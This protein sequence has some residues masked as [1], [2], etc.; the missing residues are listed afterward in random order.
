MPIVPITLANGTTIYA[1]VE[2]IDS[3]PL[4]APRERDV[5]GGR[6]MRGERDVANEVIAPQEFTSVMST[7]EGIAEAVSI[8][9]EKSSAFD[10]T[11]EFGLKLGVESGKLT[12]LFV[13]GT[14]EANLKITLKWV[15][16]AKTTE[17]HTPSK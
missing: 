9:A 2:Q 12:S 17:S 6:I 1:E 11:V 14:G 4:P 16:G 3:A 5:A 15:R 8:S 13:K 10:M 7:V